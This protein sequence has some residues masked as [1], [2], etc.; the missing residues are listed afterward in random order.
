MIRLRTPIALLCI[1]LVLFAA[2]VPATALDLSAV[3]IP[4]WPPF[5][6]PARAFVHRD[7]PRVDEQTV[8]LL[9]L[10]PSRAPPAL[11]GLLGS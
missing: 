5:A 11:S 9:V 10:L 6:T 2:F 7:S 1:G 4:I 8:A 3:L